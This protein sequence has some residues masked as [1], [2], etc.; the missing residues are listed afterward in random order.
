MAFG[1]GDLDAL[2]VGISHKTSASI[3]RAGAPLAGDHEGVDRVLAMFGK[4]LELSGGTL[5]L[6]IHDV[7]AN[8][9]HAVALLWPAPNGL[10]DG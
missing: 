1:R 7:I 8:D 5:R 6:E 4:A 10:D 3:T 9:Q 2:R